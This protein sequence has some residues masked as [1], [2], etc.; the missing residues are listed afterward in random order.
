M[1]EEWRPVPGFEDRYEVS[2]EGRVRGLVCR[3]G[4]LKEPRVLKPGPDSY[5]HLYVNLI[6]EEHPRSRPLRRP[7]HQLVAGAFIGPRPEGQDTR[8]LDG[9]KLNNRAGNLAYGTRRQN[10]LDAIAHGTWGHGMRGSE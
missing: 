1:T 3:W 4:R 5:G 10:I 8:H 2:D 6:S 9:N 7:V